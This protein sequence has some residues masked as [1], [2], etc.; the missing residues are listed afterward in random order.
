MVVLAMVEDF[1]L[2]SSDGSGLPDFESS[3]AF[4]QVITWSFYDAHAVPITGGTGDFNHLMLPDG[5]RPT[6]A[7]YLIPALGPF[8]GGRS[9]AR[10]NGHVDMSNEA[11]GTLGTMVVAGYGGVM[12]LGVFLTEWCGIAATTGEGVLFAA[13]GFPI[14]FGFLGGYLA[15]R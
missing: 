9:I 12:F 11:L 2:I 8:V 3:R 7:Y 5:G 4:V 15:D 10:S 1:L 14:V 6:T 13:I